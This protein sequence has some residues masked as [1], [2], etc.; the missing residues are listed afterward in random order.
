MLSVQKVYIIE[1]N[2]VHLTGKSV[3]YGWTLITKEFDPD[4]DYIQIEM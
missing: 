1:F 3:H 2:D 4:V